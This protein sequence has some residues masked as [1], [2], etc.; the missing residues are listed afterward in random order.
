MKFYSHDEHI[1]VGSGAD[2]SIADLARVICEVVG[3][4]GD[5]VH[6]LSKPDGTPQKLMDGSKLKTLN[7]RPRISLKDGLA[8]TY[9]AF[10]ASQ[11]AG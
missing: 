6:D 7:W 3:F 10:L 2:I 4:A 5:I 8:S 9:R 1:N 11:S